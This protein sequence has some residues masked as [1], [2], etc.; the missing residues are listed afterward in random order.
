MQVLEIMEEMCSCVPSGSFSPPRHHFRWNYECVSS[1]NSVEYMLAVS[2]YFLK[3]QDSFNISS[4][5]LCT[6]VSM[7]LYQF[8]F[9]IFSSGFIHSTR[10]KWVTKSVFIEWWWW[11]CRKIVIV[12][13]VIN[14]LII[15]IIINLWSNLW[16]KKYTCSW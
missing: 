7:F 6:D 12:F 16:Q 15:I 5:F 1:T 10:K 3:Q 4:M 8:L 14:A 13:P 2:N 11:W 9:F